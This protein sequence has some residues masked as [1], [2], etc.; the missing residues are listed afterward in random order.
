MIDQIRNMGATQLFTAYVAADTGTPIPLNVMTV[1]P[2]DPNDGYRTIALKINQKNTDV[3]N[4][5]WTT[6]SLPLGRLAT[7]GAIPVD[8]W[9][10][11]RRTKSGFGTAPATPVSDVLE[12]TVLY[13]WKQGSSA[14]KTL[15]Q[16]QLTFPARKLQFST[17]F[18]N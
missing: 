13:R 9:I 17:Q 5:A 10:T 15:G 18:P 3:V 8:Y 4:P 6:V 16:I 14:N 11:I 2:S 1:D 12:C 7:S